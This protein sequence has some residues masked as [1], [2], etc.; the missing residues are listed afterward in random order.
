MQSEKK[1]ELK[2][3]KAMGLHKKSNICVTGALED[4]ERMSQ[5]NI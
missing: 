5:Q 2:K 4:E 3:S 1:N